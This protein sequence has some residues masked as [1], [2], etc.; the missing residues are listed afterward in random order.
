MRENVMLMANPAAPI[1][2]ARKLAEGG[3]VLVT[4]AIVAVVVSAVRQH[5]ADPVLEAAA[6]ELPWAQA[7][8]AVLISAIWTL[9]SVYL[10][11]ALWQLRA[12]V[13]DC[14]FTRTAGAALRRAGYWAL[15]AMFAK[16]LLAPTLYGVFEPAPLGLVDS[17]ET[18]DIGLSGCAAQLLL[19]GRV[20]DTATTRIDEFV[21]L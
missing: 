1:V 16:M 6:R 11:L 5:I 9:P 21:D 19:A 14:F 13:R 18:F 7:F 3:S 8:N 15:W 10:I 4:V 12:A 17:L 20:L 2:R